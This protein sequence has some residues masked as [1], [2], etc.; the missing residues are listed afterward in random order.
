MAQ[1]VMERAGAWRVS[2]QIRGIPALRAHVGDA[3]NRS[4][5][6]SDEPNE[7]HGR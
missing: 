1:I 7:R 5:C 3:Q 2:A 6:I 4:P